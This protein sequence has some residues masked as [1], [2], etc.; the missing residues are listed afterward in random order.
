MTPFRDLPIR[1]KLTLIV[2]LTSGIALLLA[3]VGFLAWDLYRFRADALQDLAA[4]AD[5]IAE[6]TV[7]ALAFEDPDTARE[8]LSTLYVK[9]A[10]ENASVYAAD[11][12]LFA[13]YVRPGAPRVI[14]DLAPPEGHDFTLSA[15]TLSRPVLQAGRRIGSVHLRSNL[16]ELY[17]RLEV[18]A[19]VVALV[20]IGSALVALL[21]ATRLKRVISGPID[22]LAATA[23]TVARDKDYSIRAERSGGDEVGLLVEA[24]ND[25]LGRI[26]EHD[27]ER[28]RLL[29]REQDANRLKD[30]F[31]ATLSHE[32]R[33]P[34]NAILGW[35]HLLRSGAVD[36][37]TRA[38]ALETIERNARSQAH[39]VDDLLEISR[40]AAGKLRLTIRPVDLRRVVEAAL[41]VV[42]P[43]AGARRINLT[44]SLPPAP[45]LV[46]GD[47]ERLQQLVWNLLS[48]AV[49]FTP[50]GGRVSVRVSAGA[51]AEIAVTDTGI[52]VREAFLP[53]LFEAFRQADASSTREHGG[54]G[55][56]LAIVRHVA[57]LHGGTVEAQS[58]GEGQGATFTARF[59]RLA[60]G[61]DRPPPRPSPIGRA[62]ATPAS[63]SLEGMGVLVV[64]DDPDARELLAEGLGRYGADVQTAASAAEAMEQFADRPPDV[65]VSDI[66]MQRE[67]GY[68][69]LR[70]IRARRADQ[71]GEVPAIAV[72]AYAGPGAEEQARAAGY[73]VHLSKPVDVDTLAELIE[74]LGRPNVTRTR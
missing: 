15:L 64:D 6:N 20:L 26:A 47:A 59:P 51:D 71:G 41:D 67:D 69:L 44:A 42:R 4:Q 45:V 56:G 37:A 57:E 29:R 23:R 66:A 28:A 22:H 25:M 7:A 9:P 2:M 16:D 49:K 11:G 43:A 30:E 46:A 35:L 18:Q 31:L 68:A 52:G 50:P 48:N 39:L 54:L 34:L 36:E 1:R 5:I 10:I 17:T 61:E 73:Q 14:P 24:F 58:P 62:R 27:A 3:S 12:R 33:T 32:L 38:R 21:V 40:I 70:R 72:T 19:G 13:A 65:I 53:H 60:E 63:R 8:T 74:S 55:L